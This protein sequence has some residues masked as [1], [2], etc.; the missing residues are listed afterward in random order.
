M[1]D[2]KNKFC[3]V[4]IFTAS[5][6]VNMIFFVCF[7]LD[8]FQYYFIP[9]PNFRPSCAAVWALHHYLQRVRHDDAVQRNQ[10][11]KDP[12]AAERVQGCVHQ[13]D[14]LRHLVHHLHLTGIQ[15]CSKCILTMVILSAWL[16]D[17]LYCACRSVSNIRN[18]NGDISCSQMPLID[19]LPSYYTYTRSPVE[20]WIYLN[21]QPIESRLRRD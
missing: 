7:F 19:L 9:F 4:I 14:L 16:G 13:P 1:Y 17:I 2:K 15:L 20:C 11:A 8:F 6:T 5:Q 21:C 18:N 10:R 12:W 3:I